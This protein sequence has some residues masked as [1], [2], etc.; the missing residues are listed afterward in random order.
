LIS[1]EVALSVV[2]LT[3]AGLMIR[4]LSNLANVDPGFR[5]AHLLA[6]NLEQPGGRYSKQA[7]FDAFNESLTAKL[8]ELPGVESTARSWPFDLVSFS[9]TPNIRFLDKPVPA[10]REPSVQIALV[11]PNYFTSMGVRPRAG[12]MFSTQDR[13]GAPLAAVVNEQFGRR[14][15]PNESPIGKRVT[16]V[17]WDLPGE[18]EIVGVVANTLRAGLVGPLA[19]ELYI[20][21][22]QLAIPGTTL[23]VRTKG[24]P[25]Q[26][27]QAIRGVVTAVDPQVAT[28]TP[29]RVEDALWN[30]VSNR[31]FTRYQLLVFAGLAL[32]LATA[33][34]YG[35]VSYSIT[36]RTQEFGIR[37]ALGAEQ[38]DV[39]GLVIRRMVGPLAVG[40]VLGLVSAVVLTRYL[41]SQLY[42]V[43]AFDPL[44]LAEVAVVLAL[45]ALA[46]CWGPA[47]RAGRLDP[48]T[49][50][51]AE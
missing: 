25:M 22:A 39:I 20:S 28:G 26:L 19:P 49:V 31:R 51:R 3:G 41:Q 24:D 42:G 35:V 21:D 13:Q 11:S 17:K 1:A 8:R 30:T 33:G 43:K 6:L 12:R 29:I 46:G 4:T 27:A 38:L 9:V 18:I 2:L 47:R 15:Y 14:F 50:L 16:L 44:T 23:L 37:M 45:A 32:L 34:I 36:Q 5:P 40:L 7:T 10:G 48:L